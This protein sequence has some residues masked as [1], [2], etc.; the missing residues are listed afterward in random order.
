[1]AQIDYEITT[2]Y[3]VIL[4]LFLALGA[5]P[6]IPHQ[7]GLPKITATPP[8]PPCSVHFMGSVAVPLR[9]GVQCGDTSK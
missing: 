2:F 4:H 8:D 5:L 6:P 9:T 7:W 3:K 1:M